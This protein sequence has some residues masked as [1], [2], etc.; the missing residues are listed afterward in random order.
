MGPW[1]RSG[2]RIGQRERYEWREVV[3]LEG[4]HERSVYSL[5]WKK[6]GKGEKEGG[7]GRIATCAGDGRIRI[8]QVVSLLSALS[9]SFVE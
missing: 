9:L 4:V 2:V 8:W 7:L 3:K 5:D 1:S 6:G